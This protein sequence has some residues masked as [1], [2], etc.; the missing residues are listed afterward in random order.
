MAE[1]ILQ[2]WPPT[3][4]PPSDHANCNAARCRLP[5]FLFDGPSA[6]QVGDPVLVYLEA[7]PGSEGQA[8]GPASPD[9]RATR[10][11]LPIALLCHVGFLG[12][13]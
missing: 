1:T 12:K 13:L 3:Q 10:G 2:L 4:A 6:L 9:W 7:G 8:R 5:D 11:S